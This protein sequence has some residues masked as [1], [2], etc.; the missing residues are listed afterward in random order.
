MK[1][2]YVVFILFFSI[3]FH[4]F[5]WGKTGHRVV[6]Q[7]AYEHLTNKA[8]KNIQS[9]LGNEKIG[10][11]G[12]YMDFIKSNKTMAYMTPWH[13]CTVPDGRQYEELVVPSEGDVVESIKRI[14]SELEAKEFTYE[15]ESENLKYLIHLVG[16]IHQPLHVGN[17]NDR[18]GND[19]KVNFMY[20]N[21]NL[22]R[23]WDSGMIDFQQLSYTEYVAWINHPKEELIAQ[24][25]HDDVLD[26]V[27]E[28]IDLRSQ[29]YDIPKDGRLSYGYIYKNI[30]TVNER[31]L[32]AG[33]RLAGILNELYG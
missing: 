2:R 9:I 12:N 1:V 16:D 32:K 14:V 4:A 22:H 17:G 8:R 25:Q 27:K 10:M 29:V 11:V 15:S 33:I 31:L 20:E 3:H 21:S 30:D 19:I 23:V 24:W 6:G 7:I 26:W 13:Y 5:S 28:C 18:G